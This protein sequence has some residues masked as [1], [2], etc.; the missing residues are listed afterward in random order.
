[1]RVLVFLLVLVNLL[2]FVWTQGYFGVSANQDAF[3]MQQQMNADQLTV[4]GR[5]DPPQLPP[6]EAV[7]PTPSTPPAV[8]AP[9]PPLE[10]PALLEPEVVDKPLQKKESNKEPNSCLLWNEM[11]VSDADKLERLAV[12]KFSSLKL[13]RR[14]TPGSG[15]W[16]VFIPPAANRREA[17]AKAAELKELGAPEYF[18][19]QEAGSNRLAISLGVFS[20]QEAAN[21]RLEALRTKG[22]NGVRTGERNVKPALAGLEVRGQQGQVNALREAALALLPKSKVVSCKAR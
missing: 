19:V 18:I 21:E 20:S 17:E 5:G 10:T 3:R 8:T 6:V 2:F 12:G 15:T 1:M 14:S 4:I 9:S 13:K 7:P 11:V 22:V 16:W